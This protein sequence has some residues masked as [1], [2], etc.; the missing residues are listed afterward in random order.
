M[1]LLLMAAIVA[2][3]ALSQTPSGAQSAAPVVVEL[4][5]SEGC[6]SC[7]PADQLLER[8]T[9][10]AVDAAKVV[11]LGEHVDY[12]DRLGWKDR[13]SSA[14]LTARQQQYGRSFNID[15]I[16]TP[17]MV[18]DGRE[19]F[20]GSDAGRA[21]RAIGKALSV[22]H[23]VL[24]IALEL[25]APDRVAVTVTTLDVP[26]LSRGDHAETVI[27][28]TEDHLRSDVRSGENRGR[29]LT[30]AAVVRELRVIRGT[31]MV[32]EPSA[33]SEV[34]IAPDWQREQLNVV[35]FIQERSSRRVLGAAAVP[36]PSARR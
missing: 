29:L 2:L 22:P 18:V 6:S 23:A 24:S 10:A 4:F 11:A 3:I 19:E 9:A 13:F 32:P 33:R 15:A 28:V 17:Q 26:D 34:T 36:L 7:P 16:Y 14:A 27:A 25:T 20:V 31:A 35:A 1:R 21:H 5:T 12:W 8:L 30:H